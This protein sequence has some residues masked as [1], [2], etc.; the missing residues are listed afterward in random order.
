MKVLV[1][2][3]GGFIG[4]HLV[5]YLKV[6]GHWVRGVDIRLPDWNDSTADE[7]KLLDLRV[8]ENAVVAVKDVDWVF[9]L[10]TDHGGIGYITDSAL[11]ADILWNSTVINCNTIKAAHQAGVERY[12]FTSS[13]CVYP[14]SRLRITFPAALA[15]DD[16][17]PALPQ[18]SYGWEKLHTEHLC[19]YFKESYG[20]ETRI[21]RFQTVYGPYCD[22]RTSKSKAPP[23]LARKVAEAK[24]SG[25][26]EVE[27]W[28]D[29]KQT[30]C[31]MYIDD[32][33]RGIVDL[34]ESDYSDPVTLGPDRIVSIND[35]VDMLANIAGIEVT[36][37]HIDGPQGVRGRCFD[38]RRVRQVLGWK[39]QTSL[40]EGL[41]ILY[42]WVEEQAKTQ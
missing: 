35:L 14:A 28:G 8:W 11:Q 23:A 19:K 21:V 13:V 27:V 1:T 12:L 24:S 6:Q 18:D 2:G 42:D 5:N 15:E 36:K 22:W 33:V 32:C 17:Y 30:R 4:N 10:A 9:A 16:A 20:F 37:K 25:G 29:G 38:H 31:F 34:M 3:A 41:K 7:F 40:E 39:S 26:H